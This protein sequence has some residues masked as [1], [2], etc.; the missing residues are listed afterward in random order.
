M[1]ELLHREFRAEASV[2]DGRTIELRVVPYHEPA[3]VDDGQGPY[4]EEFAPGAFD[5]QTEFAHRVYLNFQHE[6]GIRSIV[7]KGV[8]L[9][10][11]DDALYGSFRALPDSD[12]D[13]ALTLVQEGVLTGASIEFKPKQSVRTA[14]GIV[15]RVKAHLDAVALCRVGAYASAGVLAVREGEDEPEQILDEAVMPVPIKSERVERL[16][17]QGIKLPDRYMAHPEDPAPPSEDTPDPAPA[18]DDNHTSS[19]ET[20]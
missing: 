19:E 16:R 1:T 14:D 6:K 13:K 5:G 15:R 4:R 8:T 10:S 11:R 3:E 17:A 9:E 7:G 12:G 20:E 2:G 18:D